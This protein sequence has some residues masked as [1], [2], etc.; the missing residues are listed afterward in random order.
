MRY[1]FPDRSGSS[2]LCHDYTIGRN[3]KFPQAVNE[4]WIDMWVKFDANF[5]T[6]VPQCDGISANGYKFIFGRCHGGSCGRY[7]LKVGNQLSRVQ[8]AYAP[9]LNPPKNW[10]VIPLPTSK[11]PYSQV[12]D[13]KW[14]RWRQHLRAAPNGGIKVWF[15]D[16]LVYDS[17]AD[18]NQSG[19]SV[20]ATSIYGISLGRNM[21]QGPIQPQSLWWGQVQ[22]YRANPGW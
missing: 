7:E 15:D 10:Q 16:T 22:V 5:E 3:I 8:T 9:G 11:L 19:G 17:W 18:P 2:T 13:G 20:D 14:H 6:Y 4:V 21:N 1:D 12:A